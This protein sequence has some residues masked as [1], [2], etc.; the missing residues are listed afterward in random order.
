MT[1]SD[2]LLMS[3]MFNDPLICFSFRSGVPNGGLGHPGTPDYMTQPTARL[4]T[5]SVVRIRSHQ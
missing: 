5:L 2:S 3:L 1:R 4:R